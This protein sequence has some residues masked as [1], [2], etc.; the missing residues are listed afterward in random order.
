[1]LVNRRKALSL[2]LMPEADNNPEPDAAP[3]PTATPTPEKNS[4]TPLK[5]KW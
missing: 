2:D 5:K 3:S 1:M 4:A